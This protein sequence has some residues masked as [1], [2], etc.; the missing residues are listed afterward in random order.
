[1]KKL[2]LVLVLAI[3]MVSCNTKNTNHSSNSTTKTQKAEKYW[4]ITKYVKS[5]I[6]DKEEKDFEKVLNER[7]KVQAE[8]RDIIKNAKKETKDK[9]FATIKQKRQ[10]LVNKIIP[11]I[12]QD[13]QIEFSMFCGKYNKSIKRK[14]DELK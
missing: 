4:D 9:D 1:M 13:K 10:D 8:I 6:T 11:Y 5:N 2:L 3:F 7:K 14:L 12:Q